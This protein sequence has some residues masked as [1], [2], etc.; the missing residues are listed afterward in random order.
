M[1]HKKD[2][3]IKLACLECRKVFKES[4]NAN[5]TKEGSGNWKYHPCHGAKIGGKVISFVV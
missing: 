4:I 3:T 5:K 2:L 1:K